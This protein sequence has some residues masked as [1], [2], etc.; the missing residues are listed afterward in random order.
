MFWTPAFLC[1]YLALGADKI[2][3][4]VDYPMESNKEAVAFMEA[5][6]ICDADKEKVYHINAEK[7][8]GL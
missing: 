7:L 3:F 8:L 5:L 4:A 6:P 1:A 2:L